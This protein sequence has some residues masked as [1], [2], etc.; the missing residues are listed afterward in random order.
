M[1]YLKLVTIG[2]L[3]P[4]LNIKKVKKWRSSIFKVDQE[5]EVFYLNTKSDLI[6]PQWGY[7]DTNLAH[8]LPSVERLNLDTRRPYLVI[9][10][11]DIPLEDNHFTRILD[12][13]R[14]VVT[15]YEITDILKDKKVPLENYIISQM[16]TYT[17]LVLLKTGKKVTMDDEMF[18]VHDARRGCLFDMCGIKRE[19]VDSCL[20]PIICKECMGKLSLKG[21][22]QNDLIRIEKELKCLN[23]SWYYRIALLLKRHPIISLIISLLVTLLLNVGANLILC[24]FS[25]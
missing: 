19:V 13:N 9:Y 23:R 7:S 4:E 15:L 10:V 2:N 5:D 3:D 6:S 1:V 16:Y 22:S 14:I 11:V 20:S 18:M 12:N 21:I 25:K 17:L 8:H 24:I